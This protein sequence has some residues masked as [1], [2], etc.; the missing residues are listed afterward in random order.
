MSDLMSR[1]PGSPQAADMRV[2]LEETTEVWRALEPGRDCLR[3]VPHVGWD[4][5]NGSGSGDE[6]T[7]R[8]MAA[9]Q[10]R[11]AAPAPARTGR[12]AAGGQSSE[13][14]VR[15]TAARDMLPRTQPVT[16]LFCCV[17]ENAALRRNV[18]RNP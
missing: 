1:E 5:G 12:A 9:D 11:G 18:T 14:Q 17:Y 8:C 7:V 3:L 16:L 4:F 15:P 6:V 13:V 2:L 10:D